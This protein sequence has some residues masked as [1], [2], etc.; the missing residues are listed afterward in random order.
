MPA[1]PGGTAIG[2]LK[3]AEPLNGSTCTD[4]ACTFVAIPDVLTGLV[5]AL[6]LTAV[7]LVLSV[8]LLSEEAALGVDE[9]SLVVLLEAVVLLDVVE[10]VAGVE[11]VEGAFAEEFV[12]D[13]PMYPEVVEELLDELALP[14]PTYP[15]ELVSALL[16]TAPKKAM[17]ALMM[18]SLLISNIFFPFNNVWSK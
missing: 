14:A 5:V 16:S 4:E 12:L 10:E 6:E 11:A 8:E 9:E 18:T 13:E 15:T 1:R 7:P 3:P 2:I 17:M